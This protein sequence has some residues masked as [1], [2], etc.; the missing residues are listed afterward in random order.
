MLLIGGRMMFLCEKCI[1]KY[2]GQGKT[3]KTGV[4]YPEEKK[5]TCDWCKWEK[6]G[7]D[8]LAFE[9]KPTKCTEKKIDGYL[10]DLETCRVTETADVNIKN[11]IVSYLNEHQIPFY[12]KLDTC[13][14]YTIQRL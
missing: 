10:R 7:Y 12:C 5:K 4:F 6:A 2:R 3:V 1:K 14:Q 13:F 9:H 11:A 8:I